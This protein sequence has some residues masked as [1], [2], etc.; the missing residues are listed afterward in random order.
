MITH[1]N[2]T[3]GFLLVALILILLP[4]ATWG[5]QTGFHLGIGASSIRTTAIETEG[6]PIPGISFGVFKKTQVLQEH[7]YQWGIYFESK[8][9]KTSEVGDLY[10]HN[11]SLYVSIPVSISWTPAKKVQSPV[12]A[13]FGFSPAMR[14]LSINEV[15]TIPDMSR[16]DL[17]LY[18]GLEYTLSTMS[19][20]V[21][22][23]KGIIPLFSGSKEHL[24][25]Q[26]LVWYIDMN[27]GEN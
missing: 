9:C 5:S 7:S 27:I 16:W 11:L 6:K 14:I 2:H 26:S 1:S 22:L 13:S 20:G 3:Q 15:G 19:I 18:G 25:N 23:Q 24:F 4:N 8:G 17:A 10:L 12:K 21:R